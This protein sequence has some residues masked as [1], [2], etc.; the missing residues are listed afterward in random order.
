MSIESDIFKRYIPDFNKLLAYGF[1]FSESVYTIEKTFF[2][3][4]FK[5]VVVVNKSGEVFAKVYDA[6]SQEEYV[7]LRLQ[8]QEGAFVGEVKKEYEIFLTE[9]RSQCFIKQIFMLAQSNRITQLIYE[10]YGDMPEFL[11]EQYQGSGIFRNPESEKWYAAIL[12]VDRSKLQSGKKGLI[13][14]INLKADS[15]FVEEI[16]KKPNFY[17]AYHMNKKYWIS[18]ILDDSVDDNKIMELIEQSHKYTEKR[19]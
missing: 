17:P 14:V 2:E 3:N 11:W 6:E 8:S 4:Q 1:N 19:T 5:A 13:E 15:N 9:I 10:R 16:V 18:V 12:D 7:P